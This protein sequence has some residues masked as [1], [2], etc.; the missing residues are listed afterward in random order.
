MSAEESKSPYTRDQAK[1]VAALK[2]AR[3]I[4]RTRNGL[5]DIGDLPGG[6]NALVKT[7][8]YIL[9]GTQP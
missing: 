3:E 1:R 4:I 6:H 7:A 8:E 9:N 2:D 5:L